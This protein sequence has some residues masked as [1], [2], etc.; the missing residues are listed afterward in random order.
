MEYTGPQ[1]FM[2]IRFIDIKDDTHDRPQVYRKKSPSE[3]RRDKQRAEAWS[4]AA[5]SH[6]H[7][8]P[9]PPGVRTRRMVAAE[10]GEALETEPS[11]ADV[12]EA[13]PGPDA[14]LYPS[15]F[16]L[17]TWIQVKNV[18]KNRLNSS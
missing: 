8:P 3:A 9:P 1:A 4:Q 6:S 11:R 17:F 10:R 5:A 14:R 15:N 2:K 7:N 16:T 18:L 13:L 12:S